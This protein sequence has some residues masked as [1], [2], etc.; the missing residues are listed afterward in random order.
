MDNFEKKLKKL[1]KEF[2]LSNKLYDDFDSPN[3]IGIQYDIG[4]HPDGKNT[5]KAIEMY[6][7]SIELNNSNAMFNLGCLYHKKSKCVGDEMFKK[8]IEMYKKSR[9]L[10][11]PSAIFQLGV[12]M[13]N[14]SYGDREEKNV[15]PIEYFIRACE[16][17]S[18]MGH[19]KAKENLELLNSNSTSFL[20]N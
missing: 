12:Q 17:A 13:Y 8:A 6:K 10:D 7:K 14:G 9:E 16:R 3:N 19:I 2:Y 20:R 15:D 18:S 5:K 1:D 4:T 11:N